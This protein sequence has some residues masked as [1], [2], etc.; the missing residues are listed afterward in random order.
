MVEKSYS[1]ITSACALGY[2][3]LLVKAYPPRVPNVFLP[4]NHG[5]HGG[6]GAALCSLPIGESVEMLVKPA[7]SIQGA[8]YSKNRWDHLILVANG[9][10]IA[11][12]FQ[13]MRTV[14]EDPDDRTFVSLVY[15]NRTEQDILLRCEI[16]QLCA[17]RTVKLGARVYVRHVLSEP[18]PT[19]NGGR[20]RVSAAEIGAA[21]AAHGGPA[22]TRMTVVCGKDQFLASVCGELERVSPA[23]GQ[24][25]R[26][27]QGPVRGILAELG[28]QSSE[29]HRL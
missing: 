4:S 7:H 11:P 9:T 1:P 20:G 22:Q 16:E 26:K 19:W 14:L 17:A 3:D 25:A 29:V 10:G 18:P 27:L 23:P 5:K 12:L 8:P 28:F 24:K 21:V 2:F 6:L 15:A 13:L